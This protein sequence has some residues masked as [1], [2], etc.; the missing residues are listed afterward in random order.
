MSTTQTIIWSQLSG[1]ML[2]AD[3][4]DIIPVS[5]YALA[6]KELMNRILK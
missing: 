5:T 1:S 4:H 2:R 6:K 3:K